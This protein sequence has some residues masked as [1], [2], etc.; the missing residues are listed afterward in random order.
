[1]SETNPLNE[2][3]T[4]EVESVE[5]TPPPD[6]IVGR[7]LPGTPFD[8][9]RVIQHWTQYRKGEMPMACQWDVI[10]FSPKGGTKEGNIQFEIRVTPTGYNVISES[11]E[12]TSFLAA[13]KM[14]GVLIS[15]LQKYFEEDGWKVDKFVKDVVKHL[16]DK[17]PAGE[18]QYFRINYDTV[19]WAITLKSVTN[20]DE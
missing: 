13:V 17:A 2:I 6:D 7:T 10:L 16:G 1:M 18:F 19:E 5:P 8:K 11:G 15:V 12:I 9:V 3:Q 20:I 14:N 4:V